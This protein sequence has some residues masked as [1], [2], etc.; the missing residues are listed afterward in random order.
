MDKELE[1]MISKGLASL[2]RSILARIPVWFASLKKLEEYNP[3]LL[4]DLELWV[5]EERN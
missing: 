3:N 4:L 2:D 5:R 1:Q